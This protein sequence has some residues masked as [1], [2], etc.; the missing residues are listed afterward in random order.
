MNH[1]FFP[2]KMPTRIIINEQ[3]SLNPAQG[4]ILGER[5]ASFEFVRIPAHGL[6]RPQQE[7]LAE[8]LLADAWPVVFVSPVPLLLAIMAGRCGPN[9][10]ARPGAHPASMPQLFLFHNDVRIK[11]E[12]ADG[13]ISSMLAPEGWELIRL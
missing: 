13:R 6:T 1:H 12:T 7:A 4:R 2:R 3:H 8:K 10:S 9:A 11:T 5:F